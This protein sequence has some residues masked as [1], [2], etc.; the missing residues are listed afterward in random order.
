MTTCLEGRTAFTKAEVWLFFV[1]LLSCCPTV[2][3]AEDLEEVCSSFRN[4]SRGIRSWKGHV[5]ITASVGEEP[6]NSEGVFCWTAMPYKLYSHMTFSAMHSERLRNGKVSTSKSKELFHETLICDEKHTAG[7]L[8]IPVVSIEGFEWSIKE[9]QQPFNLMRAR[10]VTKLEAPNLEFFPDYLISGSGN[11]E[12]RARTIAQFP[13]AVCRAEA[14]GRFL[15]EA[16]E[17][18]ISLKLRFARLDA[19]WVPEYEK[20]ATTETFWDWQAINGQLIPVK[21]VYIE[22]GAGQEHVYEVT[23]SEV[24]QSIPSER[25]SI[26]S[27]GVSEGDRLADYVGNALYVFRGGRFVPFKENRN[28][29]PVL[30]I[31]GAVIIT[32]SLVTI[33]LKLRKQL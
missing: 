33:A 20:T 13:G 11:L 31:I 23:E 5:K 10:K 25:F 9:P 8:N 2:T 32:A 28:H 29:L 1:V 24:N 14:G 19:G 15:L 27:L 16:S 12:E 26:D 18:D 6:S 21:L 22:H 30:K 17:G 7:W 3:K 4:V